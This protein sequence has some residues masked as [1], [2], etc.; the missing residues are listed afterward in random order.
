MNEVQNLQVDFL[1]QKR[2]TPKKKH[3]NDPHPINCGVMRKTSLTNPDALS[4]SQRLKELF[5]LTRGHFGKDGCDTQKSSSVIH[6]IVKWNSQSHTLVCEQL[7]EPFMQTS[8][9]HFPLEEV[10]AHVMWQEGG[11]GTSGVHC[12]VCTPKAR[13]WHSKAE[14]ACM[15]KQCCMYLKFKMACSLYYNHAD[16]FHRATCRSITPSTCKQHMLHVCER[17]HAMESQHYKTLANAESLRRMGNSHFVEV[18]Q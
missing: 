7:G 6:L 2:V 16:D 17:C 1:V 4:S 8:F 9:R 14:G 10:C 12:I 11:L 15:C 3:L 5:A 13:W 18:Q